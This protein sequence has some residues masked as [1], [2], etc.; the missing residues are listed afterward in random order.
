LVSGERDHVW[1]LLVILLTWYIG[2]H[3]LIMAEERFHLAIL[4]MLAA[5]AGRGLTNLGTLRRGLQERKRWA[6]IAAALAVILILLALANWGFELNGNADRLMMLFGP[7]GS[8]AHFT[9]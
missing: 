2:V 3:M 5:L 8:S 4:P 6:V 9:Y 1:Q 7:E